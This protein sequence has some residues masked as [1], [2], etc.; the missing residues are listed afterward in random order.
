M[1]ESTDQVIGIL[2]GAIEQCRDIG[3]DI[4]A[5]VEKEQ[6]DAATIA[7]LRAEVAALTPPSVTI[8][9]APAQVAEDGSGNLVFTLTRSKS[10]PP[11]A[12]AY[13]I[14][15]TATQGTDY[16]LA[17]GGSVT[18]ADGALT[19]TVTV[20][21]APDAAVEPDETVILTV[22]PGQGY[23]IGASAAAT[24]TIAND[25]VPPPTA[26]YLSDLT[27]TAVSNGW[28]P[29]ERDRSNGEQGAADG[30]PITIRGTV[31]AKGLGVHAPSSLAYALGGAYSRFQAFIG[32]DDEVPSTLGS[33]V[34]RVEADGA[35]IYTSP[36]LTRA[37]DV[38]FIDLSVAGIQSLRLVVDP[39]GSDG[40]DHA[41][42]ADAKLLSGAVTP[43][44]PPAPPVPPTPAPPSVLDLPRVP[45]H[46]GPAYY[47]RFSATAQTE[48][49]SPGFFPISVFYG[50]PE[51]ARQLRSVGINTYMR[52]E[53]PG[54]WS[55][56]DIMTNEGLWLIL[57]D[58]WETK[59]AV[60]SN[61]RVI[62]W[63]ISEEL[64]MGG[65]T[66][67]QNLTSQRNQAAKY[68]AFNDG[69]FLH[70]NFGNGVLGTFWAPNTMDDMIEV[71]DLTS[72]DKYG[73]T[74]PQVRYEFGRTPSWG[75]GAAAARS[76]RCYGW[77]QDRMVRLGG[78]LNGT[79]TAYQKPNWVF[80]ESARP[81]IYEAGSE[82]IGL[83]EME[84]ATWNALIH[85]ASGLAWFQHNNDF[86]IG[87]V[88]SLVDS[89]AD[90]RA[91]VTAINA[92][93]M[94]MAPVLNTQSYVWSFG[95]NLDTALKVYDGHAYIIAMA[96][97]QGTPPAASGSRT[98]T[99]PPGI[100]GT[101]VTVIDENRTIP[102]ANRAFTDSFAAEHEHHIYRIPL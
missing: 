77:Q 28:G 98:F 86:S 16:S 35:T 65:G 79:A 44:T 74:S 56:V 34:F 100:N 7:A 45:W 20:D 32:I 26:V 18:F 76:S 61:P 2:E 33:V 43:P 66:E 27:P 24:G 19:A 95:P 23:T 88:Y 21:P 93:V 83:E 92:Q 91:K 69:R 17:A 64:D 58:G 49:V 54:D 46:G 1:A 39:N 87:G 72:V 40:G 36:I 55:T 29:Y 25:D 53:N 68:R 47:Q 67:Q 59:T 85:G 3:A 9:V 14:G 42:W 41:D 73:Y 52:A 81:F 101:T 50:K 60:R 78:T 6:A 94:R 31:Y 80:V 4:D 12:V 96:L 13:S 102:V 97:P 62:G 38:Q 22:L 48:W 63:Q 15:G 82:T 89:P 51:H 75:L 99:L 71:V 37:S 90:R 57:Q 30:R 11:L 10:G 84:G 70:S 5:M 8:G